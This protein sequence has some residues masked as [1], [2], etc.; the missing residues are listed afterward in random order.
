MTV[1]PLQVKVNKSKR[2]V[3]FQGQQSDITRMTILV[4]LV[5][6]MAIILPNHSLHW[7]TPPYSHPTSRNP[8]GSCWNRWT[9]WS[10]DGFQRLNKG[11]VSSREAVRAAAVEGACDAFCVR[12]EIIIRV[13]LAG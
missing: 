12:W 9:G 1:F 2:K 13:I 3:S 4:S 11:L 10:R 5:S 7:T 6:S 8:P